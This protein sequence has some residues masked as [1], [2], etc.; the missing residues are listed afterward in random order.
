MS[1]NHKKQGQ[2]GLGHIT[3]LN[4]SGLTSPLNLEQTSLFITIE[5]T[6]GLDISN[7]NHI[8][9]F[10]YLFLDIINSQLAFFAQGWS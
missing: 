4:V 9:L 5:L 3:G 7:I 6:H 1:P 10:H 2:P 8:W